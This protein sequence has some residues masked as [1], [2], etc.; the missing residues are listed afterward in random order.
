MNVVVISSRR[1]VAFDDA[2]SVIQRGV[3]ENGSGESEG[4]GVNG[5]ESYGKVE[6]RVLL[7]GGDV[8]KEGA[9]VDD[10]SCVVRSCESIEYLSG[11]HRQI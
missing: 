10:S 3:D 8:E 6:G 5:G 1:L 2:G 7:V 9:G 4:E 11:R